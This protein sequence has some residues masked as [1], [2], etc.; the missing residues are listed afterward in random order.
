MY[1]F[2]SRAG[3]GGLWAGQGLSEA[4][5][6][7]AHPGSAKASAASEGLSCRGALGRAGCEL[8]PL[9]ALQWHLQLP[10]AFSTVKQ[11]QG[12]ECV[13]SRPPQRGSGSAPGS[14]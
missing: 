5:Q 8:H 11:E 1:T 10:W 7:Q 9:P 3:F 14:K 12:T 13:G 6:S 2:L 4:Q